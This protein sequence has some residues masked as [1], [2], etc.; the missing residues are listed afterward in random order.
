MTGLPERIVVATGNEGKVREI[1][2]LLQG[3]PVEWISLKDISSAPEVVEDGDTFEENALKKARA[4]AQVTGL[5]A[6]ADDSGLC[7]DALG[8]R[9]G[10]H[11]ARYAGENASDTDKCSLLLSEL[12]NE[13]NEKRTARFVCVIAMVTPTGE[14]KLFRGE[15]EGRIIRE[16]RGRLGFGYDPVFYYEPA[17]ATFAQIDREEKNRVSHRGKALKLFAEHL[18]SCAGL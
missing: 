10:V 3:L 6:I 17:A 16:M 14:E 13:P 9:P 1:R 12:E 2:D 15:C 8:G 7:V 4:L 11:S 5:T 18:S